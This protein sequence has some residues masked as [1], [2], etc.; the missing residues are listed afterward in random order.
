MKFFWIPAKRHA[1]LLKKT[2]TGGERVNTYHRMNK[3]LMG[4][5]VFSILLGFSS[6]AFGHEFGLSKVEKWA[7]GQTYYVVRDADGK[8]VSRGT[9]RL[10]KWHFANGDVRGVASVRDRRGRFLTEPTEGVV[11]RTDEYYVNSERRDCVIQWAT[12][13]DLQGRFLAA[14]KLNDHPVCF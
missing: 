2:L 6:L 10:E 11:R 4:I 5:L 1:L 13:R 3:K 8:F 9:L 12:I 14:L 7:D